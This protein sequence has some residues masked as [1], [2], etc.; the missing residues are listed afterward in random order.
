MDPLPKP[1]T[2]ARHY[3]T[4]NLALDAGPAD[5]KSAY[6]KLVRQWHPDRHRHDPHLLKLAEET[7]KEANLAYR[8]ILAVLAARPASPGAASLQ[9]FPNKPSSARPSTAGALAS[10]AVRAGK[11][12]LDAL[13]A[14]PVGTWKH[15]GAPSGEPHFGKGS[16]R[17]PH[18]GPST[19]T[20][21][22]VAAFGRVLREAAE[23]HGLRFHPNSRDPAKPRARNHAY[24]SGH[25]ETGR[26]EGRSDTGPIEPVGGIAPAAPVRRK[27]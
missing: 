3:R 6:R 25:A 26:R 10:A 9:N 2:L 4:L 12:I 24:R 16:K 11:K 22:P 13:R 23:R 1:S 20:K 7:L 17:Y 21:R 14:T 19:T 8:E 5:V 18:N 15:R 27:R